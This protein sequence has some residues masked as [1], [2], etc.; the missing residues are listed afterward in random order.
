[1]R[2]HAKLL[3]SL[4]LESLLEL[5]AF[6]LGAVTLGHAGGFIFRRDH[7]HDALCPVLVPT[8]LHVSPCHHFGS[9]LL[10]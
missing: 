6:R 3:I 8:D 9:R 5:A 10:S 2:T 1:M 4:M 7:G